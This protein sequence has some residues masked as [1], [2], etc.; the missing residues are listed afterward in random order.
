[1]M[2]IMVTGCKQGKD[3]DTSI[4]V[5]NFNLSQFELQDSAD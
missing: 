1:M 3:K 4:I 2:K 5:N